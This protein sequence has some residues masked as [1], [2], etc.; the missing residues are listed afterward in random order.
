MINLSTL[1]NGITSLLFSTIS[2]L[3]C[4]KD[5]TPVNPPDNPPVPKVAHWT[6][7][8]NLNNQ[9]MRYIGTFEYNTKMYFVADSFSFNG[10]KFAI[11]E[12]DS[13]NK[14]LNTF[15]SF[16]SVGNEYSPSVFLINDNLYLHTQTSN[17][18]TIL[19][20]FNMIS[21]NWT[22]KNGYT[23]SNNTPPT[24]KIGSFAANNKGYVLLNSAGAI[25][26]I[27]IKEYD[28]LANTWIY[29]Y[30]SLYSMNFFGNIIQSS[31]RFLFLAN[32]K[33][34][35]EYNI[36][37]NELTAKADYPDTH[38][39]L[40][41]FSFSIGDIIH[42]GTGGYMS[43]SG[44]TVTSNNTHADYWT[45]NINTNVW[46]KQDPFDGGNRSNALGFTYN[47]KGYVLGGYKVDSSLMQRVGCH[48]L[49]RYVP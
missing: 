17:F 36:N 22:N 33:K 4:K 9:N 15:T 37:L 47:G 10:T 29:K 13:T 46:T 49:W 42:A 34:L 1:K 23:L 20:S 7:V 11:F 16:R 18:I 43:S 24:I 45:Y 14:I 25:P 30:G 44:N 3:G 32:N 38:V 5:S 8:A 41:A 2:F 31:N 6:K 19:R 12:Y 28:P 39:D 35:A 48:D 21:G 27:E 40:N 26:G